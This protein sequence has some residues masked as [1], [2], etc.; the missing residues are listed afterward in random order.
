MITLDTN[1]LLPG[2]TCLYTF[3]NKIIPIYLI[4]KIKPDFQIYGLRGHEAER[5][6][7]FCL[8]LRLL[9]SCRSF[10]FLGSNSSPGALLGPSYSPYKKPRSTAP[11]VPTGKGLKTISKN[12][13]F[14]NQVQST[15]IHKKPLEIMTAL[16]L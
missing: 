13:E 16:K 11:P 12:N 9:Q 1:K 5:G 4:K 8:V 3:L 2:I 15:K 6:F 10:S 14:T 7:R